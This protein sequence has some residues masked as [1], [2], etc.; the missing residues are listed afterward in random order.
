MEHEATDLVLYRQLLSLVAGRSVMFEEYARERIFAEERYAGEVDKILRK[1]GRL[2]ATGRGAGSSQAV[3]R[4]MVPVACVVLGA[5]SMLVRPERQIEP[6]PIPD[7][8]VCDAMIG[9]DCTT[10]SK[11][12]R[13]VA[14]GAF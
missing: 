4:L 14:P 13:A 7:Q 6:S 12:R 5:C 11:Q 3:M 10:G 9:P 8:A 1:L 2:P